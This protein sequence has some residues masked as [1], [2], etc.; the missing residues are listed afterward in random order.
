[1]TYKQSQDRITFYNRKFVR[2]AAQDR[3]DTL[4]SSIRMFGRNRIILLPR[5]WTALISFNKYYDI[6]CYP[7]GDGEG[8]AVSSYKESL[9]EPMYVINSSYSELVIFYRGKV[10]PKFCYEFDGNPKDYFDAMKDEFIAVFNN[11]NYLLM[12]KKALQDIASQNSVEWLNTV[13]YEIKLPEGM[14]GD[15]KSPLKIKTNA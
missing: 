10:K 2:S 1:M 4:I 7:L 6:E 5:K 15:I 13:P 14:T 3:G 12:W 9:P 11:P 8:F